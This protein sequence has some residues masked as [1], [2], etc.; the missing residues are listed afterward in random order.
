[1]ART[2]TK[3]RSRVI[4][5]L[6]QA[7][8]LA[9]AIALWHVFATGP[10]DAS[11]VPAPWETVTT[12]AELVRAG[13]Y[14]SSVGNT[15]VTTSIGLLLSL[16]VGVPLGL[17]NGSSRKVAMSSQF[18]IDFGRTIPGVAALPVVLLLFGGTRSMALVLVMFGAVWPLLVQAT[19][20]VQQVSP[21]LHQVGKAFHLTLVHRVR[22]IYVPSALPFLMTGLRIAATIS[23]LLSISAE[24]LGGTDGIGRDL[25]DTLTVN[26]PDQM[27]VY[28]F[29]AAFL[30]IG[31]N[32]VLMTIQ[33]RVLR[34]HPSQ[35]EKA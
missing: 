28:A 23:L 2:Q 6:Q 33:R 31:L 20:A 5:L 30:G 24:F 12:A 18:L 8:A 10:G 27:F 7:A 25:F 13:D 32:F 4:G 35:R 34:W 1:M 29:T 11:G 19:Y 3:T 26:N 15:L 16:A 14:W 22:A 17:L 21:Q 9:V